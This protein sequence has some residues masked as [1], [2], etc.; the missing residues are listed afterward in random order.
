MSI[1]GKRRCGERGQFGDDTT[2]NGTSE[3]PA[4]GN[5][6]NAKISG[7]LSVNTISPYSGTG[8]AFTGDI[9]TNLI[10]EKTEA[11]GFRLKAENG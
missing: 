3:S 11:V 9:V 7:T 4:P 8:T 10:S 1:L 5:F 6:T 2:R